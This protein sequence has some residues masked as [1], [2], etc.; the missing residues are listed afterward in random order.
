MKN[1]GSVDVGSIEE[2]TGLI[3]PDSILKLFNTHSEPL[4][5]NLKNLLIPKPNRDKSMTALL[6]DS[7][8]NEIKR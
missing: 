3:D 2:N 1:G 8:K 5:P 4:R 6:T 7:K